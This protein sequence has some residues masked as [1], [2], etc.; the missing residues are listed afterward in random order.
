MMENRRTGSNYIQSPEEKYWED[1]SKIVSEE[2]REAAQIFVQD[3]PRTWARA[4][5]ELIETRAC[6]GVLIPVDR[7]LKIDFTG[8]AQAA[9]AVRKN[10]K[11]PFRETAGGKKL[12]TDA[13]HYAASLEAERAAAIS[14]AR[15]EGQEY[16]VP[17]ID[18]EFLPEIATAKKRAKPGSMTPICFVADKIRTAF[19]QANTARAL[20]GIEPIPMGLGCND[21]IVMLTHAAIAGTQALRDLE[22]ASE[23]M[24]EAKEK[25][26][27]EKKR[28]IK[29]KTTITNDERK[30][31]L[32][33][34][35]RKYLKA[36]LPGDVLK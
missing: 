31:N 26:S 2:L 19:Q 14:A 36:H 17:W 27:R 16:L 4:A 35:L 20:A 8:V 22:A 3:K 9:L 21:P 32:R 23:K 13:K 6:E 5:K 33:E 29:L 34:V 30:A 10:P 25:A 11:R 1:V 28:P 24:R 15:A 18:S 12:R 7:A